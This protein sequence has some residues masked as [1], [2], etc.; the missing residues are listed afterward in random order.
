MQI[1]YARDGA[2]GTLTLSN[3]PYNTLTSPVF[4]DHARLTAFLED[5]SLKAVVVLGAGR[6][7][8][9]GADLEQLRVQSRDSDAF[10]GSLNQGKKLL[11]TIASAPVPIAAAIRGSCLGAGLEIALACHF[12]VAAASAMLGFPEAEHGLVPGLGGTVWGDV[13]RQARTRLILSGDMVR[14]EDAVG[15]GLVDRVVPPGEVET[16]ARELLESLVGRRSPD[17][18]HAAMTAIANGIRLPRRE[19]LM[20]ETEIFCGLAAREEER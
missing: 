18:V 12:R 2:F 11:G 6:N 4:A 19:A 7:F 1:E 14:G 9:G 15:T 17:L 8:C 16:A 5:P 3:P 13:N 10:A 20:K